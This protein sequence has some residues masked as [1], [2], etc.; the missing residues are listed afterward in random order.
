MSPY[1]ILLVFLAGALVLFFGVFYVVARWVRREVERAL[2]ASA[3]D[4]NKQAEIRKAVVKAVFPP[5][6]PRD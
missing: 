4:D 1:E 6:F 2:E 3:D 5:R